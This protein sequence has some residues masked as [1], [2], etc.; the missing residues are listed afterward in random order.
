[1]LREILAMGPETV[2]SELLEI[3]DGTL[4]S[5]LADEFMGDEWS[6]TYYFFHALYLLHDLQ[7]PEALDVYRRV[8]HLDSD[9][10]EFWFGD[11]LFE[12]MPDLLA[13]AGLMRLPELLAMLEDK[14]MLLQ[15]WLVVSGAI[16]RLAREQ[17]ELRPAI[18]AFFA[19]LPAP[20]H[21]A[22]R[23]GEAAFPRQCTYL[24]LRSRGLFG[25]SAG[26]YAG[27]GPARAGTRDALAAPPGPGG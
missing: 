1:M 20:H 4:D 12:E 27:R 26:R 10:T 6:D 13:C 15:H 17:P 2:V 19:V 5:Y 23:P 8:L 18:S 7:A 22:R 9:S 25:G 24:W 21:R 11:L 16:A 14:K 3:I